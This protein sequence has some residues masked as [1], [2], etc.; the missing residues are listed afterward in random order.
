[1][2]ICFGAQL[3]ENVCYIA[4]PLLNNVI[5]STGQLWCRWRY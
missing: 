3:P 5:I 2:L 4:L 1:L